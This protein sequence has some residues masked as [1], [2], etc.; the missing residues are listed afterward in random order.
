MTQ[1]VLVAKIRI[2]A[3]EEVRDCYGIH[4]LSVEKIRRSISLRKSFLFDCQCK[5]QPNIS[6]T[7]TRL[8]VQGTVRPNISPIVS[9]RYIKT[10]HLLDCQCKVH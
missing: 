8:S 10:Q 2:L 4:H 9:A 5:V 1:T 3:G 7:V 6:S